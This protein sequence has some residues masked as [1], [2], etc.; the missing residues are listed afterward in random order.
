MGVAHEF[1]RK[2]SGR[3][4]ERQKRY[5]DIRAASRKFQ[6]GDWVWYYYPPTGNRK[7]GRGWLGHYLVVVTLS[8][9]FTVPC[10]CR[11]FGINLS[12]GDNTCL[13]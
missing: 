7:L 5:Y 11:S 3:S 10:F 8:G 13:R 6:I 9:L 1:A 2:Q 4:A 12:M